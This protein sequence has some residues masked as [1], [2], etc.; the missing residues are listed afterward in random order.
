MVCMAIYSPPVAQDTSGLLIF[1]QL[2]SRRQ[3]IA[4]GVAHNY[5]AYWVCGPQAE[6]A[7][8]PLWSTRCCLESAYVFACLPVS[9]HVCFGAAISS[10]LVNPLVLLSPAVFYKMDRWINDDGEPTSQAPP[11]AQ[12]PLIKEMAEEESALVWAV[13]YQRKLQQ[14]IE[15]YVIV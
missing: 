2:E 7:G 4:D 8:L 15:D 13:R 3:H 11:R 5:A 6:Q 14:A 10:W 12:P 1:S 9:V